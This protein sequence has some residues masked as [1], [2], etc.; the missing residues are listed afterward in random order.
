EATD[1]E[2]TSQ[3]F[4]TPTAAVFFTPMTILSAVDEPA[5][6]L[7]VVN[8]PATTVAVTSMPAAMYRTENP[9]CAPVPLTMYE[10]VE[11]PSFSMRTVNDFLEPRTAFVVIDCF[12]AVVLYA[13]SPTYLPFP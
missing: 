5:P 12:S 13:L 9:L 4:V 1:V 7:D 3:D 2:V 8:V 6:R 11:L 10:S